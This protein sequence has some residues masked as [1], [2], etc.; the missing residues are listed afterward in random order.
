MTIVPGLPLASVYTA[1][2]TYSEYLHCRSEFGRYIHGWISDGVER[3]LNRESGG[4]AWVLALPLST[5]VVL[6]KLL[7]LTSSCIQAAGKAI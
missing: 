2:Y 3:V 1:K 6:H 4:P 5:A 7:M